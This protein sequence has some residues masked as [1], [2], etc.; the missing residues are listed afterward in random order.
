MPLTTIRAATTIIRSRTRE[1]M[2]IYTLLSYASSQILKN[3]LREIDA[4]GHIT[5]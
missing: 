3:A 1:E 4:E 2:I 5:E